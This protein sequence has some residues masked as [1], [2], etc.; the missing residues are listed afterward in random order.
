MNITPLYSQFQTLE[1]N[2]LRLVK[3][4]HAHKDAGDQWLRSI[5]ARLVA[6]ESALD[7][8]SRKQDPETYNS[9]VIPDA[10]QE[11]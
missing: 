10:P 1:T 3:L 6:A 8:L 9:K 7:K 4:F 2:F 11:K 5:E